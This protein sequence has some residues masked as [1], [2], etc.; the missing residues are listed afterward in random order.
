MKLGFITGMAVGIPIGISIYFAT[1]KKA[2]VVSIEEGS[3]RL[4]LPLKYGRIH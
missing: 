2:K 3:R 1:R 4:T